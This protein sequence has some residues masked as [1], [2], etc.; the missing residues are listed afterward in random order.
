MVEDNLDPFDQWLPHHLLPFNRS[1]HH[2]F[3][4]IS[5]P[6]SYSLSNRLDS[7]GHI[8]EDIDTSKTFCILLENPNGL[9]PGRT[10]CKLQYSLARC[11][12]L[13]IG[14]IC[15]TDTKLYWTSQ[16]SFHATCWFH[17]IWQFSSLAQSQVGE[18]FSLGHQPGG[19]LTAVVDR[20]T[21]RVT[22]KGQDPFG[23]GRWSYITLRG[24]HDTLITIISA[25]H[26][27]QKAATSSGPKM[28]YMQQLRSLQAKFLKL[29]L[30]QSPPN[31]N[32]QFILDLHSWVQHLQSLNHKIILSLDNNG[33]LYSLEGSIHS[34]PFN[35]DN[36]TTSSQHDGSNCTLAASC[37]LV[38]VLAEQHS[39]RPFPPT[40]IRG[41]K[42]LD[43]ILVSSSIGHVIIRFG[44]LPFNANFSGDHHSCFLDFDSDLLFS[45]LTSPF[46]PPCQRS[47]QLPDSKRVTKYREVLHEQLQYHKIPDKLKFLSEAAANKQW[48]DDCTTQY[49][50]LDAII[51]QSMLHTEKSCSKR[52]TKCFKW[53][54]A[55]IQRIETVRYW[56]LLLKRSKSL[57]IRPSTILRAKESA[58]LLIEHDIE[59][60]P[61]IIH[62]LQDALQSL[63]YAQKTH[64]E[65]RE[66]YLSGLAEAIFL[67][68]E[69]Y[70]AKKEN[71][72]LLHELTADQVQKLILRERDRNVYRSIKKVLKGTNLG[73]RLVNSLLLLQLLWLGCAQEIGTS[74]GRS[75]L[76]MSHKIK[77]K[78]GISADSYTNSVS[79]LL[80][81]PGQGSTPGPFLW[82][83]CFLLINQLISDFPG[84]PLTN[85]DSSVTMTNCGD[86]FVDDSYFVAASS[87]PV[88]PTML[89]VTNSTQLSQT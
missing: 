66:A 36:I 6:P 31:P 12:S 82:I 75:W 85:P 69:P 35:P 74:L 65:L 60:Q 5:S 67:E 26:V 7:W 37:G 8:M 22:A 46:A 28:A 10:D 80:F 55:L 78:Y 50:V 29:K 39:S 53:S 44:I 52:H 13:G 58:H 20:W 21:S 18:N 83:L 47:L 3:L 79:T 25:Y 57:P 48:T 42:R 15:L 71:S 49:E 70:L 61:L 9:Q 2:S 76:H 16:V 23:L 17:K 33:Y 45:D 27:C 51:T 4:S 14:T 73:G 64:V 56:T 43:Y 81:G 38:D 88:S 30:V 87:D 19:A 77:T 62:N 59:D 68:R 41:K 72:E 89:A 63:R 54:P 86:A 11:H 1:S 40:Y 32:R 24:K 84:L 34:L